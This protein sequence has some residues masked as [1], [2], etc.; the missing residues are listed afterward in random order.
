LAFSLNG[1]HLAVRTQIEFKAPTYSAS[2]PSVSLGNNE[3]GT[4][5]GGRISPMKE[6]E[7]QILLQDLPAMRV[8]LCNWC[9]NEDDL[10]D[11]DLCADC[12]E[13]RNPKT[14]EDNE[15]TES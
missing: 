7:N 9:N 10:D 8:S 12:A 11:E 1:W 15:Q 2:L 5:K 13:K 6:L 4:Y 14:E 3:L